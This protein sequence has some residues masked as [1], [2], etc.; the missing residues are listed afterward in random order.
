V[1]IEMRTATGQ[2]RLQFGDGFRVARSPILLTELD[3]L[4]AAARA[5]AHAVAAT[6]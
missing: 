4:L 5:E 1:V 2:R 6:V 3:R